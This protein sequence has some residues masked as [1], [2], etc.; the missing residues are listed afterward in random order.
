MSAGIGGPARAS[1]RTLA[2]CLLLTALGAFAFAQDDPAGVGRHAVTSQEYS[3]G[4]TAF[5]PA[6]FPGPVEFTA[7][8]H[9]PS[10]LDNGPYPPVL[11]LHGRHF[12]CGTG[13][14]EWPC[15]GGRLP[16]RS[17][18]G[19][20]YSGQQLASNGYIVV[21]VSANG[22]N[23]RDN[24]VSDL[25]A[26]ARAELIDRH[27]EF[28]RT[29]DTVGAAPFGTLFVGRVDLSRVGT[30]GHSRGGEG[31][32]RHFSYNAA[33]A[34]PFPLKV[35]VPIAPTNFSRW[36]V[37]QAVAVAQILAYCDGDVSNLQG[38]H[39]Y[40]DAR[41]LMTNGGFQ[42]YV[43]V[44]GANHNFFN[45][46]WTPGLGPG[47][48]DDWTVTGDPQCGTG[49]GTGR[50]SAADQRA[51]ALAYLASF[52]R[53]E[54]GGEAGYFGYIDGSAGKP[55]TVQ[56]FD[57]HASFQGSA[58]QRRD[59]N[60][61]LTTADLSTDFLGGV[62]SQTGLSPQDLCGGEAPQPQH[63]L[64]GQSTSRMPHTAPSSLSS[65][66]GLS[67]LRT[68]WST[69]GAVFS[70]AIPA[71][72][73][74]DVSGF[75]FLQFRASV[76]FADARNPFGTAQDLSV[77][78]TDG[79]GG[80][81][82]VR[83]GPF[84]DA[85]FYPPGT[86]SAVPKL[87]HHTLRI[88]LAALSGVNLTNV[89]EVALVFDQRASGAL[90][91]SDLHFYRQQPGPAP[92]R[93]YFTLTPCRAADTRETRTPLAANARRT[94]SIAGLCGVPADATAVAANVAVVVPGDAGDLRLYPTG[95]ATPLISTINFVA[96]R[97]RTNNAIL[98]LG[99]GGQVD[100][101][102]DMPAG[103]VGTTHLVLDVTGYF[104]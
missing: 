58:A 24:S 53:T 27:L 26:A 64:S 48:A 70:N 99:A 89:A 78:L 10:D 69:P 98:A 13:T 33:K 68:G 63:C 20:D 66:R 71:G 28:W 101:Q 2:S 19:Y 95:T 56:T 94:F 97:T 21:S 45:T 77:R 100:V 104:R 80:S 72:S 59:V 79:S 87:L 8:V 86:Q 67:Q 41:Y 88:P 92:G 22:I 32:M 81:A 43:T 49:A 11:Y 5:T 84:S 85:L 36:Q 4:D 74:R 34:T 9:Y 1:A 42:S 25:G 18:R 40:D 93:E 29:L 57:L 91:V 61:L 102:C 82:T 7:V 51:V 60:R 14:L 90:L 52:F 12:T 39:Y 83:A 6:G 46:I 35:I 37:N 65:R 38:V 17:F 76:N 15:T 3:Q 75:D 62:V 16:V 31:V 55:P 30:M 54:V 23:A 50:L 44:M 96:G 103:S 73:S 47:A